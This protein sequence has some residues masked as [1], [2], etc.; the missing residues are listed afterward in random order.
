VLREGG[1]RPQSL[2]VEQ[3]RRRLKEYYF[4]NGVGVYPTAESALKALSRMV[5]Y[6]KNL[7]AGKA[8]T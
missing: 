5:H 8:D 4:S 6:Y 2:A 7:Q 3:E 1:D